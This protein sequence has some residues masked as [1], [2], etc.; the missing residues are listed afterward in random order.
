M[1][2]SFLLHSKVVF[3]QYMNLFSRTLDKAA[4][5][6]K[7]LKSL[8]I[9]EA[10][11]RNR[12]IREIKDD[13]FFDEIK[14]MRIINDNMDNDVFKLIVAF[15]FEEHTAVII[16]CI[17]VSLLLCIIGCINNINEDGAVAG[18]GLLKIAGDNLTDTIDTY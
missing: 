2:T 10:Y 7:K 13:D 4:R 1:K 17:V 12:K 15:F 5:H 18:K 16:I 8:E 9:L 11:E 3:V 14:M 6:S